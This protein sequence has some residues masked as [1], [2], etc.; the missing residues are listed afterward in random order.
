MFSHLKNKIKTKYLET[1]YD[2]E[3]EQGNNK[4][5]YQTNTLIFTHKNRVELNSTTDKLQY[6]KFKPYPI[7]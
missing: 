7:T 4:T 3:T 1:S 5:E 6:P 2:N